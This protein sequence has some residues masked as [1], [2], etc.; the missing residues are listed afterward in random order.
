VGGK[1]VTGEKLEDVNK[2]LMGAPGSKVRL[3]LSRSGMQFDAT[4]IRADESAAKK[5][6]AKP[7]PAKPAE[8][9]GKK[10]LTDRERADRYARGGTLC[11]VRRQR[12]A[13]GPR[14]ARAGLGAPRPADLS[15]YGG[16]RSD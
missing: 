1:A 10:K 2:L 5:P 7:A 3:K 12:C 6:A 13:P 11:S 15:A 9:A 14:P 16:V 4:L 8:P